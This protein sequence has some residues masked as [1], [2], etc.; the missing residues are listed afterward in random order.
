[1][2]A[3]ISNKKEKGLFLKSLNLVNFATFENQEI[4][5][6]SGLNAITGETGSGKSLILDALQLI[7]GQRADKKIIRRGA[8]FSSIEAIFEST[9]KNVFTYLHHMGFPVDGNEIIIKRIIYS[10]ESTKNFL[11]FQNCP[12]STL[13]SFARTFIDLVGQFENQKLLSEDYQLELLDDFA[14]LSKELDAYQTSYSLFCETKKELEVL[15]DKKTKE[16]QRQ[17]FIKFQ[18]KEIESLNPSTDDEL[19]LL[20][21]K[22][23]LINHQKKTNIISET[24]S[25]L[26]DCDSGNSLDMLKQAISI[27]EK[28]NDLFEKK[29]IISLKDAALLIEESSFL[30]SKDLKKESIEDDLQE[31]LDRLDKY[32]KLKRK[33][34]C[35]IEQLVTIYEE[36]KKE[37]TSFLSLDEEI[38]KKEK[39]YNKLL[40]ILSESCNKLHIER[41]KYATIFSKEITQRVQSLKMD[42]ATISMHLTKTD[43]FSIRGLSKASLM[44]E[45]NKGEGIFKIKDIA[46]GGELSRILLALR[47]IMAQGDSISVFLFDEI[48]TGIGGETAQKVGQAL[49]QVAKNSQ[50]IAITHLPQ[51]ASHA[52]K[53]IAVSKKSVTKNDSER[54]FSIVEDID[55]KQKLKY[56]KAMSGEV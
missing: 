26:T 4:T 53:I 41:E 34:N 38:L 55:E 22:T 51:I 6:F 19:H 54:T 45:T 47:Q 40:S 3:K 48:D 5:F 52:D 36:Y 9:D 27:L 21:K 13:Q 18:L 24:L 46:S 31:T 17:D 12:L 50:V 28:N 25:L 43:Q 56:L 8:D 23:E 10:N 14:S 33:F 15:Q 2:G 37:L 35:S 49:M 32:Q 11:N 29:Q 39:E 42:G 1:M 16:A 20:K 44:A 7:F 30:I